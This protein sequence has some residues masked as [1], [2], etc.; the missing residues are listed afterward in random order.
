MQQHLQLMLDDLQYS[1]I[2]VNTKKPQLVPTQQVE[3]VGFYVDFATVSLQVPQKNM[4]AIRRGL[5]KVLFSK[6]MSCRKVAA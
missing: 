5:E 4:K 1:G 2:V 3:H 6:K